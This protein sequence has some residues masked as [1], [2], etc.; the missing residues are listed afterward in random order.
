MH[1][2]MNSQTQARDLEKEEK[3]LRLEYEWILQKESHEVLG[4][5]RQ[6]LQQCAKR[7]NIRNRADLVKPEKFIL[8]GVLGGENLKCVATLAGEVIYEADLSLSLKV[9]SRT[10]HYKSRISPGSPWRLGQIQD[11]GNHLANALNLLDRQWRSQG[12]EFENDKIFSSGAEVLNLLDELLA[13]IQTGQSEFMKPKRRTLEEIQTNPNLASLEPALPHDVA[14]SFYVQSNNLIL[15]AYQFQTNSSSKH[16]I[17]NQ[18]LQ[19]ESPVA[20]FH[21]VLTLF[22]IALQ[23]C[24][25]LKDKITMLQECLNETS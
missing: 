5:V 3:Q 21:D 22:S 1:G 10:H 25:Q 24:Q 18:R 9:G 2:P 4:H 6:I 17:I 20:W 14:L 23:L 15:S 11:S 8:K 19:A 16:E 12:K 13:A 7:F